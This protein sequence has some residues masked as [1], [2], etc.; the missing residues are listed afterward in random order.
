MPNVSVPASPNDFRS[1]KLGILHGLTSFLR[2]LWDVEKILGGG[3][4][5]EGRRAAPAEISRSSTTSN[6]GNT[7]W[8]IH[9][10]AE[11]QAP[12]FRSNA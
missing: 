5:D 8:E 7:S 12:D 11:L 2:L 4:E 6:Y 3:H 10:R 9:E 1:W